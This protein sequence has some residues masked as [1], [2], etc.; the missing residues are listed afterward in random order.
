MMLRRADAIPEHLDHSVFVIS[1]CSRAMELL[2]DALASSRSNASAASGASP[3][4]KAVK[5]RQIDGVLAV[6]ILRVTCDPA[7]IERRHVSDDE[8]PRERPPGCRYS[9]RH[10]IEVFEFTVACLIVIAEL[11]LVQ[12]F[13]V[14]SGVRKLGRGFTHIQLASDTSAKSRARYAPMS[15]ISLSDG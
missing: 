9:C 14:V 13:D 8:V 12:R 10:L 5:L 4:G 2:A 1:P 6:V 3:A 7:A 11:D 15:S